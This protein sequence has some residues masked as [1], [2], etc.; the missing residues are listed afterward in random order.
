MRLL[1]E[2]RPELAERLERVRR[3]DPKR[4]ERILMEAL[5]PRIERALDEEAERPLGPRGG[6]LPPGERPAPPPEQAEFEQ[7][8]RALHEEEE[9]LERHSQEL[10]Q[11]LRELR[12]D[13]PNPEAREGLRREL[14]ET[15]QRHFDVRGELRRAEVQQMERE[16]RNL[17]ERLERLQQ[18]LE[19]RA[20]QREVIVRRRAHELLGEEGAGW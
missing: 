4:F 19:R 10:A 16:L 14:I 12:R 7:R 11:R 5:A 8:M 6:L 13:D 20:E 17:H 1:A 9:H 2:H 15:I 18:D 3:E